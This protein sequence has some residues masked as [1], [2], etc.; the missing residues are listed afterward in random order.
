MF[1]HRYCILK[2]LA[3]KK[4]HKCPYDILSNTFAATIPQWATSSSA[5]IGRGHQIYIY[6][7]G[8]YGRSSP[9]V[10]TP[11]GTMSPF[12]HTLVPFV[13]GMIL[14]SITFSLRPDQAML[15]LAWQKLVYAN[16]I[17]FVTGIKGVNVI[18]M[19]F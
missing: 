1:M 18:L 4:Y 19:K 14:V 9:G 7:S 5:T 12:T 3:Y 15:N 8:K 11:L 16:K 10:A 2:E 17:N 13:V 6:I